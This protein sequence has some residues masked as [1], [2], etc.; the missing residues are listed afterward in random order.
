MFGEEVDMTCRDDSRDDPQVLRRM[1]ARCRR[2]AWSVAD[3]AF[4]EAAFRLADDYEARAVR[5]EDGQHAM[6]VEAAAD[7]AD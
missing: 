2:L 5:I 6:V 1:A 4:S 7:S 3:Q